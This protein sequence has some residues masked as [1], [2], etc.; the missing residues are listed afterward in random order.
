MDEAQTLPLT[1]VR[2]EGPWPSRPRG[3]VLC[4]TGERQR[5]AS[6]RRSSVMRVGMNRSSSAPRTG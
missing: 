6:A 3:P 1:A 4:E 2:R 5:T